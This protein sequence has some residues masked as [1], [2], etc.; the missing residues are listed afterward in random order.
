MIYGYLDSKKV[1]VHKKC[2][3]QNKLTILRT[4]Y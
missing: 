3:I 1:K 2:F 4:K